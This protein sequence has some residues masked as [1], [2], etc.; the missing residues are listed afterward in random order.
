M[1]KKISLLMLV[2]SAVLLFSCGKNAATE[3][4]GSDKVVVDKANKSVTIECTVSDLGRHKHW[5]VV[6]KDGSMAGNTVL[7]TAVTTDDFY[8]GIAEIAGDKIWNDKK[9]K[10][11]DDKS[12]D[13]M[14]AEGVGHSDFAKF[15]VTVSWGGKTYPL[16]DVITDAEF[17]G[18]PY[19]GSYKVAFAGNLDNQHDEKTG[20]ITC[21]GGCY[22]GI[23]SGYD[24]PMM[25]KYTPKNLPEVGKTVKVTYTLA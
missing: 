7:T 25:I 19:K 5:F 3:S 23:T 12:I 15:D 1:K 21:F 22:M 10:F 16:S 20:C 6:N 13:D 14:V 2:L 17:K 24:T 18:K 4:N 9:I 11:D 8:N